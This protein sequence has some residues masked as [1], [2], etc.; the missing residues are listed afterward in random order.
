MYYLDPF[1]EPTKVKAK[2]GKRRSPKDK[3]SKKD[4]PPSWKRFLKVSDN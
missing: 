2:R 4:H 3:E 1:K